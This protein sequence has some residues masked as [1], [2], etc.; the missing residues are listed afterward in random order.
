MGEPITSLQHCSLP[1]PDRVDL[2]LLSGVRSITRRQFEFIIGSIG[3]DTLVSDVMT[4]QARS[5]SQNVRHIFITSYIFD[6]HVHIWSALTNVL[7]M[8]LLKSAIYT[9]IF[10]QLK[11]LTLPDLAPTGRWAEW[12]SKPL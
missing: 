11:K 6:I 8:L 3:F 2:P 9:H 12:D 7:F 10:K 4:H 1:R 5:L